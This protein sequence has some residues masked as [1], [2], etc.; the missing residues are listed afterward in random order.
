MD[1]VQ[2]MSQLLDVEVSLP[3]VLS[4]G[5]YLNL[6]SLSLARMS[7]GSDATT[8]GLLTCLL[9]RLCTVERAK[10]RQCPGRGGKPQ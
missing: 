3:K 9:Y 4:L 2:I 10:P 6:I 1:I 8:F 5:V 7:G